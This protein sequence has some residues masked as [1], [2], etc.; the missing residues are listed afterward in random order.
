MEGD[1]KGPVNLGTQRE[2]TIGKLAEII[3]RMV[4]EK[5]GGEGDVSKIGINYIAKT[6]DDPFRRVPDCHTALK[7]L[8]WKPEMELEDGV[9]RTIEWHL[10][11]RREKE[12]LELGSFE[13]ASATWMLDNFM[14]HPESRLNAIHTSQGSTEHK[15]NP[16]SD[17]KY[18]VDPLENRFLADVSKSKQRNKIRIMKA[19]SHKTL[20]ELRNEAC[21]FDFIYVDASLVAIDVV[22]DAVNCWAMLKPLG[23]M[24]FGDVLCK[25]YVEDCC[26]P[27]IVVEAFVR[28][29]EPEVEIEETEE[30]MWVKRVRHHVDPTR[31]PDPTLYNWDRGLKR[32]Y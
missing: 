12:I 26:D 7:V 18:R 28:C 27:W 5:T 30:Q 11:L 13:G 24:V 25:E 29:V 16:D 17:D 1:W 2:T 31:N 14:D 20:T 22:Y 15:E 8:G 21:R 23:M 6:E 3:I 9:E 4:T 32:R 19:Q 10:G